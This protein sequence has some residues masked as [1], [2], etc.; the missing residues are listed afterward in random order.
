MKVHR[1]NLN[2]RDA[3]RNAI[4][5]EHSDHC[6]IEIPRNPTKNKNKKQKI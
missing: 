2:N 4:Q 1:W 6:G 5:L 3:H